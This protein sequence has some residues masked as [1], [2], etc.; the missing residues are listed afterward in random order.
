MEIIANVHLIPNIVANPYLIVDSKGL[1]LIDAGLPGSDKKIIKY[2]SGLGHAPSD[3]KWIIITHSD[4][5]HTGG[6]SAIKNT[7]GARVYASAIEAEAMSKGSSSRQ[8]QIQKFFPEAADGCC[9]PLYE[10]RA[11]ICR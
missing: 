6:L 2:I 10:S 1:A 7:S 9:R 5:D 4:M 11:R 3:L 8:N